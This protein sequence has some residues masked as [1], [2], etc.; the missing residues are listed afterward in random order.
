MNDLGNVPIAFSTV[1]DDNLISL[2][3][4]TR[5]RMLFPFL[6]D[7][8]LLLYSDDKFDNTKNWKVLIVRFIKDS[9]KFDEQTF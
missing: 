9:Q 4:V 7:C 3:I 1:S 8:G 5:N 2:L 6:Y